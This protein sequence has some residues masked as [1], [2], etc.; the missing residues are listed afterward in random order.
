[1]E[2]A[3]KYSF[4]ELALGV[5]FKHLREAK[6]FSQ[7]E[8]AGDEI[9]TQH[10]SN[11]E[12]GRTILATHHFIVLLDN[13]NVNMFE[14]QNTYNQHLQSKDVL[15]FSTEVA[16]AVMEQN[17]VHLKQLAD[18]IDIKLKDKPRN[19]KLKLDS[20][21]V[22]SVLYFIDSSHSITQNELDF[23]MNYLCGLTEWGLYDIQLLS[24]CAQFI[25]LLKLA[26]LT[27]QMIN[28]LQE[29]SK[30]H[31]IRHAVTQGVL[32]IINVFVDRKA[33]ILA[34]KLIKYLEESDIHEYYMF[35]KL[36]LIY[37]KA[38]YSYHKEDGHFP[39]KT[40]LKVMKHC[41]R[42]LKFCGCSK[43]ATQISNEF[44]RLG[45]V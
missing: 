41:Q 19:K 36:T 42:V 43:T 28:P 21:R 27:K 22:K 40:A 32:N 18:Q 6:G 38:I 3:E 1:M 8:A 35:E 15:L 44:K 12:N 33:Y 39:K 25:D 45:G 4:K 14:F 5:V 23:L 20:I 24:Q 11:F 30:L 26:E 17:V 34:G 31:Y 2:K 13:I 16:D 9:S 7:E 10:L 37:N 29:N